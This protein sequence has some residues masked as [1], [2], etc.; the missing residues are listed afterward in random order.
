MG[1]K[2]TIQKRGGGVDQELRAR[3]LGKAG[4]KKV[5]AGVLY[6]NSSYNNTNMALADKQGNMLSWSSSGSLGFK[7]TK[8]GTPFAASKVGDLM[9]EKASLFGMQE[10]DVVIKG[11]GSGREASLRS[12]ANKGIAVSSISDATPIAH[13]G[14][15]PKKPR[16]V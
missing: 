5:L 15:R 7:G 16:R 9:G 6:I 12:F 10:V 14:V 8:K 4:K 1:K 3:S 11:I 2:R 13:G